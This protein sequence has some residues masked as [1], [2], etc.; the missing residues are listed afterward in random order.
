MYHCHLCIYLT[1]HWNNTFKIIREMLPLGAFKHEFLESDRPKPELASKADLILAGFEDLDIDLREALA[2]LAS[3]KKKACEL[4]LLADREQIAGITDH[5][6]DITDIWTMPMGEEEIRFRFLRWQESC[7]MRRDFWQTSQYLEATI[8]NV[9][10]LVWYKD[11]NGIHKKVNDSFCRT[12]NKTKAQVEGQ[13]HAYIWDVEY[14]DPACIESERQVM[15]TRKTC[16]SQEEIQAG[17]GT[18]LLTTYKSPLYDL[19]GSVM[20]TVGVAI[21]VTQEK[22]Y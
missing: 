11:K 8:N 20:G 10:N 3:G 6:S 18:R 16:V 15:S 9:P 22:A 2:D 14:D 1:G 21:D 19:D 17:G 12:V 5:L 7:K 13:G 4:I